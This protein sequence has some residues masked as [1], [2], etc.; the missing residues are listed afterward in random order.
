M[1]IACAQLGPRI[2]E[3]EHNRQGAT[4]AIA[5]AASAGAALIVLPE[6]CVSGYVFEDAAEARRLAEPIDGPTVEGWLEQS[7]RAGIAI[8]GGICELDEDDEVRNS[9]VV[10]ESGE[11]LALYRKTHLW[12]REKLMFVPGEDAPS[13]VET[14]FARVGLM[15][16]YDS[17]FPE[18]MRAL[19]LAGAD[20]ILVPANNPVIGP[21]LE[22]LPVEFVLGSGAAHVNR[23]FV[24]LCDR[25]GHE[26]GI[27]WVGATAIID[28]DGRIL[29]ERVRDERLVF[30]DLDLAPARDKRLGE[31]NDVL[32]DRRP[33]LYGGL[34]AVPT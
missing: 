19:A 13:V 5:A 28:P 9:A 12:D 34:A 24:A 8:V 7:A 3:L 4:E 14:S 31:R 26:R 2:G 6:L 11:L 16:C 33:E 1:K 18:T 29:T 10:I 27:D 23:T 17:F 32:A 21:E 22:P 20:L 25:T 15:I 30:A